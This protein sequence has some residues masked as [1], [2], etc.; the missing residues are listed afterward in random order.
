M[1]CRYGCDH[2]WEDCLCGCEECQMQDAGICWDEN[3]LGVC[4]LEH[5]DEDNYEE[6]III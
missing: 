2:A 6:G 3:C 4:G 1:T 5:Q